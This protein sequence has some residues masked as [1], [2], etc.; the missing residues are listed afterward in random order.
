MIFTWCQIVGC[1]FTSA[2]D[3][4]N[5]YEICKPNQELFKPYPSI[6]HLNSR[7]TGNHWEASQKYFHLENK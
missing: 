5:Y 3:A 2:S 4:L 1:I 6:V 7:I